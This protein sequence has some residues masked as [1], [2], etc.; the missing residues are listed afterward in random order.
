MWERG[1]DPSGPHPS[2]PTC[3]GFV[4][5]VVV[6]AV[7]VGLDS[8]D[9]LPPDP[10]SAGVKADFGQS[11]FGQSIFGHRVWPANLGQSIFGQSFSFVCCCG[12]FWCGKV[13]CVVCFYLFVV[14]VLCVV[15]V[16]LLLLLCGGCV[17]GLSADPPPP[18]RPKF[19]SFFSSPA[20]VFIL[21]SLFCWSFSLNSGG[22]FEAPG[23]SNVHV[24]ALGLSCETPAA[25][26]R[27]R[28]IRAHLC[29]ETG[30]P[31]TAGIFGNRNSS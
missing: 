6:V 2:G 24:W 13:F 18:D 3:S 12:W 17:Q 20:T 28:R 4:V 26:G 16:L 27:M 30:F 9:H 5:V 10:P 7:V 22:V 1:A 14:C 29:L 19:R 31:T 21:F 11:N 8:L 25:L 15:V 23:R